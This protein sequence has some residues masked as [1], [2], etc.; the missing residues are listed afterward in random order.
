MAA[1]LKIENLKAAY[2]GIHALRGVSLEVEEGEIVSV[3]GANGA[4]KS[5]LLKC[6]SA[7]MKRTDGTI[8]FM[9]K[10][11]S[12][13]P[14]EIV[15][16]GLVQV[17]EAR[18]IFAKL[19]VAENLRVGVGTRKDT[20]G[21]KRDYER[22]YAMFP[23]LKEREKQYG[24]L[25]SGGEQQMLAIARGIM[26][27]PKLMMFDEPSL[28]LAPVIVS[29]MF[30]IIKEINNDGCSILLIEQNANKALQ[31]SDHAYIMQTGEVVRYGTGAELLADDTLSAAYL[32]NCEANKTQ[33]NPGLL[34]GIFSYAAMPGIRHCLRSAAGVGKLVFDLLDLLGGRH[35]RG[36]PAVIGHGGVDAALHAD[37][38]VERAAEGLVHLGGGGL[39]GA[40]QIQIA[41]ALGGQEDALHD[42][43]VVH[44]C[45]SL[46]QIVELGEEI[47][48]G[49][50]QRLGLGTQGGIG[51]GVGRLL[52][53]LDHK[54]GVAERVLHIE[55]F[56]GTHVCA[57]FLIEKWQR[58]CMS[59]L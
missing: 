47:A 53:L 22:V 14:H 4:G 3:L 54:F 46:D 13:K 1:I 31:I 58:C 35:V 25:L 12:N 2:G 36:I 11:I 7:V 9:G 19:T 29:Q 43:L 45:S 27:N 16:S 42:F 18:Q 30:E 57:S 41:D 33:K 38:V 39:N 5:T 56:F 59:S 17:P 8:E 24:G 10:P 6:I 50:D 55:Q 44:V 32:G 51:E 37:G 28:G 49:V 34:T 21:I 52:A 20:E 40:V 15:E 26:A 23:R 48:V